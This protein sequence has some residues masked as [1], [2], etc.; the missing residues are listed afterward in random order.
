MALLLKRLW[1]GATLLGLA[2]LASLALAQPAPPAGGQSQPLSLLGVVREAMESHPSA[3]AARAQVAA[4]AAE[5][6]KAAGARWPVVGVGASTVRQGLGGK[7]ASTAAP[8]LS[9]TVYAGGSI[10][11]GVR[12]AQQLLLAAQGKAGNTLD[13]VALQAA[14]AYL[15]WA[16]ALEQ[17]ALAVS[18]QAAMARVTD[19]VRKIVA[20]DAG[21]AVDLSQAEVRLSAAGLTVFQRDLELQQALAR[22]ARYMGSSLPT[23]P[24]GLDERLQAAPDSLAQALSAALPAHPLMQQVQA[25][26]E[27][28]QESAVVARAQ[29]RPKVDLTLSRQLNPSSLQAATV[30]QLSLNMPVFNGG[31]GEAGVRVADEQVRA[32]QHALD[33][34]ALVLREKISASWAEWTLAQQRAQLNQGQA[35]VGQKLV[36]SYQLQ[37]RLA[38]RSLLELL[39]VQNEAYGYA[40]TAIQAQYDRRLARFRLAAAMG[41][42]AA[43]AQGTAPR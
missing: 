1:R 42:L 22:L 13:E 31:A 34:Q 19:D 37:F 16:R 7:V 38:R 20:V 36:E 4:A 28:A 17:Q 40:A 15:L 24:L 27:A 43:L 32:A 8:Q 3:L 30:Q 29:T 11:A 23:V 10:E 5:V 21:R 6:E 12:R 41:D 35:L 18:N 9:Y 14:E 25:Q 33:E 26:L 2:S 39:N